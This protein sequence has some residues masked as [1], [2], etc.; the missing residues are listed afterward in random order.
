MRQFKRF[1][2]HG[3]HNDATSKTVISKP[4]LQ[5][6]PAKPCQ[7]GPAHTSQ[8]DKVLAGPEP[9]W[10]TGFA[11]TPDITSH[12][13]IW[14]RNQCVTPNAQHHHYPTILWTRYAL[15]IPLSQF[16]TI[17]RRIAKIMVM[18]INIRDQIPE[19]WIMASAIQIRYL[20]RR[21]AVP[22]SNKRLTLWQSLPRWYCGLFSFLTP[23]KTTSLL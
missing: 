13:G 4:T 1:V 5:C 23:H 6:F 16:S 9:S 12:L 21:V 19:Y 8:P 3:R 11:N 10:R 20:K 2:F 14:Y 18:D 17:G 15:S 7:S 22:S